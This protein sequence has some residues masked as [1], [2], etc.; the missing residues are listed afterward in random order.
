MPELIWQ[1]KHHYVFREWDSPFV[2]KLQKPWSPL[3]YKKAARSLSFF[4]KEFWL[5]VPATQLIVPEDIPE[6]YIIQQ[7]FIANAVTLEDFLQYETKIPENLKKSLLHFFAIS[8]N[9]CKRQKT[10]F[11]IIWTPKTEEKAW[12]IFGSTNFLV[13]QDAKLFFIDNMISH[14]SV[15]EKYLTRLSKAYLSTKRKDSLQKFH[16]QILDNIDAI[17]KL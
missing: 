12:K 2:T 7:D 14:G 16:N 4:H 1:W 15:H 11:D 13:N 6:N 9:I 17:N 5:Y 8:K 3:N 10:V